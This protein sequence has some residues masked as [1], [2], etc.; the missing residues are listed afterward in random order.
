M[1][2]QSKIVIWRVVIRPL[3]LVGGAFLCVT[4]VANA[5]AQAVIRPSLAP[6]LLEQHGGALLLAALVIVQ[7]VAIIALA[8]ENRRRRRARTAARQQLAELARRNRFAEA[9][10]LSALI[11]HEI[12]QP[13]AAIATNASAGLRWLGRAPPDLG[14]V[15]AV[16]ERIVSDAHRADDVIGEIR[17]TFKPAAED[18]VALDVNALVRTVLAH[19]RGELEK[20][21]IAV[22]TALSAGLPTILGRPAQLQQVILNVITNAAEAMDQA[23]DRPRLLRVASAREGEDVVIAVEDSGV[24]ADPQ[25]IERIFEPLFTTKSQR[26]GMGLSICRSIVEAHGG[27]LSASPCD[28]HGLALRISLPADEARGAA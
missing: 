9:A 21:K 11:A 8:V 7:A 27:R 1:R 24:G 16:L 25:D 14:E 26:I 22:E 6:A 17:A 2:G 18:K 13:L 28:P 10:E 12:K 20:R 23:T 3:A 5:F 19:L 15:R 4:L